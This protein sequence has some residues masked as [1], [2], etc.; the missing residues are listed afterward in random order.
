MA[1]KVGGDV[2]EGWRKIVSEARVKC[3][4]CVA[5]EI[6]VAARESR[7]VAKAFG[8][9]ARCESSVARCVERKMQNVDADVAPVGFV[10][11]RRRGNGAGGIESVADDDEDAAF[12]F[13]LR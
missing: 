10:D 8:G 6:V 9:R 2:V 1:A 12:E 13:A 11:D 4:M 5:D 3:G 7:E